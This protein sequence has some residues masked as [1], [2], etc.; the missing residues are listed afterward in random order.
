MLLISLTA[1]KASLADVSTIC[2]SSRKRAA[3]FGCRLMA[4][5]T[6]QEW[7]K[8]RSGSRLWICWALLAAWKRWAVRVGS[9]CGAIT[10][11]AARRASGVSSG[12][13]MSGSPGPSTASLS[14]EMS[15]SMPPTIRAVQPPAVRRA[16]GGVGT[17]PL[18][19][20][21]RRQFRKAWCAG[22]S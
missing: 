12:I 14:P 16:D 5:K 10:S 17:S 6:A 22:S 11:T 8:A 19:A 18:G 2:S 1:A 7:T 3:R 15:G 20:D 4:T 13:G 21:S 9:L